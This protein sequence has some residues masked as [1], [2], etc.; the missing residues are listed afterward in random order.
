[1][2]K[3]KFNEIEGQGRWN[4]VRSIEPETHPKGGLM[5]IPPIN[6]SRFF[7]HFPPHFSRPSRLR[8]KLNLIKP[9][10]REGREEIKRV[11]EQGNTDIGGD[12]NLRRLLESSLAGHK[13]IPTRQDFSRLDHCSNSSSKR[14]AGEFSNRRQSP[15][16]SDTQGFKNFNQSDAS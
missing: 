8:G 9:R 6:S 15:S 12:E 5:E 10:R 7:F 4:S 14:I 2:Q 11:G 3:Y 13:S 16:R 1:M